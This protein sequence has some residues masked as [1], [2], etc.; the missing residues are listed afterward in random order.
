LFRKTLSWGF[1]FV[2]FPTVFLGLFLVLTQDLQIFA[3]LR[4]S[5]LPGYLPQHDPL[6]GRV[7]RLTLQ[8]SDNEMLEAWRLPPQGV[9]S[10]Y[11]ALIFH[12]NGGTLVTYLKYQKWLSNEGLT[13]YGLDYRGFGKSTGW[14]SEEGLYTDA[15]TLWNNVV[16][17]AGVNPSKIILVGISLGSAPAAYLAHKHPVRSLVLQGAFT[18]I[19][20]VAADRPFYSFLQP[21]IWH[22][23]PTQRFVSAGQ[24]SCAV[25][26]HGEQDSI[27]NFSHLHR[28]TQAWNNRGKTQAIT[29]T[30]KL[31]GHM[32][33]FDRERSKITEAVLECLATDRP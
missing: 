26:I 33:V 19:K 21:F 2:I 25:F 15:D 32:N 27:V 22:E 18:S 30:S 28:L 12:G 4:S 6:P 14:P 16:T 13:T 9:D 3:E 5:L 20:D 31:A 10:G 8:T 1:L 24:A 17:T 23:F 7:E 11:T 29:V